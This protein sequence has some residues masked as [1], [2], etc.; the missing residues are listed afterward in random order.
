MS[1]FSKEV[2]SIYV[3]IM[4]HLPIIFFKMYFTT[5]TLNIN[6]LNCRDKQLQLIDFMFQNRID[7]LL[8]QEHNIRND[9]V[10]CKELDD[11]YIV[12][13]NLAISHKGGTAILIN[14]KS[15]IKLL[16][17]EKSSDSRII[18]IKVKIYEEMLHIINVYAHA[19]NAKD[20]EKLFN[21]DLM[22]YLRNNLQNT[23]IGGD[24]NCVLSERDTSSQN[25]NISKAL[26]NTIRTL[27]FKDM[28][29]VKNNDI[30]YTYVRNNFGTRIDR[31]YSKDLCNYV[32]WIDVVNV[33]FSDHSCVKAVIKMPNLPKVGPFYWKLN[34]SLLE[35]P[36]IE[37]KFKEEW[38]K[39]KSAQ[40]RYAN[41]NT[42][43]DSHAKPQIKKFFIK[44]GREEK[45][46]KYG[47]LNL[48][49]YSLNRLYNE[50]NISGNV[51]Y[52]EIKM[53]KDRIDNIK[54]DILNGVKI[55][56]RVEE[57][58]QGEHVSA[59]LIKKQ[60]NINSKYLITSIKAEAGILENV[61]DDTILS[62]NDSIHLYI[63]K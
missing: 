51:D 8:L 36:D 39:I 23:I 17:S 6:G 13:L 34:T 14:R 56:S 2:S 50:V 32:T 24:F 18:S 35:L 12:I 25:A 48:L 9:N 16:N 59:Y 7:I 11:K 27:R 47:L 54:S 61:N 37:S 60:M 53:T 33:H 38:G 45:Q 22:Y 19:G 26:L 57:Q 52:C 30:K 62:N 10:I 41:I 5:S 44:I 21:E 63:K 40:N 46:K 28:W 31:L 29:H 1:T 55:R 15:P 42:W 49:E 3:L 43:W 4:Y 58:L 20:R